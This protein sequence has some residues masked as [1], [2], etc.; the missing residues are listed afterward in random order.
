MWVYTR[1]AFTW[2]M[3]GGERLRGEGGEWGSG[4][5]GLTHTQQRQQQQLQLAIANELQDP[6]CREDYCM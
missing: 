3:V 6:Q 4:G 2:P 5:R 1:L